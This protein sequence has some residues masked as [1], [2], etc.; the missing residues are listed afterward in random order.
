MEKKHITRNGFE[1][2]FEIAMKKDVYT[3]TDD[4]GTDEGYT[5]SENIK[6][7]LVI[8][9]FDFNSCDLEFDNEQK[10]WDYF[11]SC[12]KCWIMDATGSIYYIW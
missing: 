6:P 11:Q 2:I 9:N 10:A 4:D 5:W 7:K 8:R 12:E 1:A 3:Q